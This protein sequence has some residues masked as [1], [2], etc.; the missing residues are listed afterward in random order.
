MA[1][2]TTKER[3]ALPKKDFPEPGKRAYP[4]NDKSHA[5]NALARVAQHGSPA[6]KK[7]VAA[8]VHKKFPSIGKGTRG[9][10]D[11]YMKKSK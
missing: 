8:K 1:K 5:R 3:K 9:T 6:E 4:V 7:E 2:L 11:G 10:S